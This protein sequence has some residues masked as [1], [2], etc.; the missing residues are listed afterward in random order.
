[1]A[2][3]GDAFSSQRIAIGAVR[4]GKTRRG[5]LD[6]CRVMPWRF[7]SL[8]SSVQSGCKVPSSRS[9]GQVDVLLSQDRS[10]VLPRGSLHSPR[11][12]ERRRSKAPPAF[13]GDSGDLCL[14]GGGRQLMAN[15]WVNHKQTYREESDGGYLW[16]P[17]RKSNGDRN[18]SYDNMALVETGDLVFSYANGLIQ[19]IG[20]ATDRGLSSPKPT[21]FGDKGAYWKVAASLLARIPDS[22]EIVAGAKRVEIG[23]AVLDSIGDQIEASIRNDTDIDS[24]ERHEIIKARR[25]QGR[26]RRNLEGIEV[27]CRI[28][29]V[30]D[31]RLLRA[32]HIKPWRLCDSNHERLDGHNGLLLTPTFDLLFDHGYLSFFDDGHCLLSPKLPHE[33]LSLIGLDPR[34]LP[35]KK[36]LSKDQQAYM[37]FH[38]RMFGF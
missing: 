26:F 36:P 35:P 4:R 11:R 13:R 16:S 2:R 10:S 38:R 7:G 31:R 25:G 8:A 22:P 14:R 27:G 23:N 3:T 18:Q 6:G 37:Q 1:M 5:G 19:Q 34:S 15:W 17:K 33:Q 30:S 9:L 24:T 12:I 20:I 29:G 21:E 32:S 28:T